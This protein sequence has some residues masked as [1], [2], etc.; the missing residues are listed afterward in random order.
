MDGGPDRASARPPSAGGPKR[1]PNLK[2][3]ES[4]PPNELDRKLVS[5]TEM[6][7]KPTNEL[8]RKRFRGPKWDRNRQT[9]WTENCFGDRNG[10]ET[11]KR[12]GPKT[13]SGT[14][15]AKSIGN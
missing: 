2:E 12:I 8:D 6:G 3:M 15:I 13:V 4:K 1:G 10:I 5:G 14:E 7:P 11:D 9:N